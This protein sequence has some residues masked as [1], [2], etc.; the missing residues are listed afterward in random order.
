[1][2]AN[3]A[4]REWFEDYE[5]SH[6][7]HRHTSHLLAMYPYNQITL[8]KTPELAAGVRKTIEGR[9]SAKD[10][11]DTEWSRANMICL[12]ARLKDAEEAYKSI[13]ILQGK[14]SREN[15][16][17]VSPGGIAGAEGDI[18][19]FDGNTA[20]TAG[21]AE[22]LVQNQEGYVE[23]LPCLPQAW[24][25]GNFRGICLRGGAEA[26]AEWTN[27]VVNYAS[28]KATADQTLKVK[29]PQ[30]KEYK[31]MLNGKAE[32]LVPDAQGLIEVNVK[33]GDLLE[34]K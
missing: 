7:N 19:S 12:Y 27:S 33:K 17:T 10:W 8:E 30:G 26:A 5:E 15:L 1:M 28:L 3:G 18:Y 25:T 32:S 24:N 23:F 16:M 13:Q 6:P 34:I 2:R 29:M 21:M 9:L 11:E 20:G 4:I 31:V 22:M 14:L